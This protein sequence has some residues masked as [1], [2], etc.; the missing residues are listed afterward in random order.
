MPPRIELENNFY[1]TVLDLN[2][3]SCTDLCHAPYFS[4][5][6][7]TDSVARRPASPPREL[8]QHGQKEPRISDVAMPAH[9][10]ARSKN[11][12]GCD[13]S[14]VRRA[15]SGPRTHPGGRGEKIRAHAEQRG[16]RFRQG[17]SESRSVSLRS[18]SCLMARG[19]VKRDAE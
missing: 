16:G 7:Q 4:R 3:P 17:E 19:R 14:H 2:F 15:D 8:G 13:A 11:D 6:A 9:V 1:V 18:D 5:A 10:T 12:A